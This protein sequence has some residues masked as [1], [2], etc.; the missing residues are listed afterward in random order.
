MMRIGIPVSDGQVASHLGHCQRF[1]IADVEDGKVIREEEVP[2]PG[3]GPGGP[4]PVFLA[5]QGVTQVV[6][7]G[8]PPHA[9]G[10][11]ANMGVKVVLGATGDPH[12]VLSD[13]LNGTLKL[14]TEGLDAGGCCGHD[15]DH[16]HDH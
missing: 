16:G 12:Q 4:P 11:F 6:A 9:Q 1:L 2:N 13:F 8:M 15:H 14:T 3:H 10:M 7:W 5:N